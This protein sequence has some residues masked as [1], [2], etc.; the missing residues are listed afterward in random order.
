MA[1]LV[2]GIEGEKKDIVYQECTPVQCLIVSDKLHGIAIRKCLH[3]QSV[4]SG[5]KT[6][7]Y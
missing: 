3:V 2:P 4:L 5:C 1:Y 7:L 6:V